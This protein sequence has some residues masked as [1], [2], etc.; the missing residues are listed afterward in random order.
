MAILEKD[1]ILN[2]NLLIAEFLGFKFKDKICQNEVFYTNEKQHPI[3]LQGYS[4]RCAS[5]DNRWDWLMPAVEKI[6]TM[7]FDVNIVQYCCTIKEYQSSIYRG[8]ETGISKIDG[9]WKCVVGFIKWY[10]KI[11]KK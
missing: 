6:E 3:Y 1:E 10:N 9:T 8:Q 4:I 7:R 11:I 2:G 5:F